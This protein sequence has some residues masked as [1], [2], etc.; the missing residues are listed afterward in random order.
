MWSEGDFGK[1]ISA[2][3][4][5]TV[6]M[7][8]NEIHELNPSALQGCFMRLAFDFH[9]FAKDMEAEFQEVHEQLQKSYKPYHEK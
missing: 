6:E 3:E 5:P 7:N 1:K 8:D 9:K 4:D 2:K